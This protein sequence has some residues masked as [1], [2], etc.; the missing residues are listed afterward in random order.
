TRDRGGTGHD[1]SGGGG[2]SLSAGT[3]G[4]RA[5]AVHRDGAVGRIRRVPHSAGV[6]PNAM[7]TLDTLAAR[8]RAVLGDK[9]VITDRQQL[10][11]Y[12]CDGLAHY[13]VTPGLVV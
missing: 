10:R 3:V 4:R 12:E 8:L 5:S 11:T 2:R 6:R 1:P 13:K 7:T 9:G